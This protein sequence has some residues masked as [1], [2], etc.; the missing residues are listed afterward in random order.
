MRLLFLDGNRQKKKTHRR[1]N[2]QTKVLHNNLTPIYFWLTPKQ[3][4]YARARPDMVTLFNK[5]GG[6]MKTVGY[7]WFLIQLI[8]LGLFWAPLAYADNLSGVYQYVEEEGFILTVF[9]DHDEGGDNIRLII[10][11][12]LR[13]AYFEG[14]ARGPV[15]KSMAFHDAADHM[16]RIERSKSSFDIVYLSD[17]L[18]SSGL[19]SYIGETFTKTRDL[20]VELTPNLD[21]VRVYCGQDLKGGT[22]CFKDAAGQPQHYVINPNTG[23]DLDDS[24]IGKPMVIDF[25]RRDAYD[26]T[27]HQFVIK[28]YVSI[29]GILPE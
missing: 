5:Y 26:F 20:M 17:V 22:A 11:D 1:T 7:K 27:S 15:G 28:E 10:H 19:A 29:Q 8:G 21:K 4:L 3:R 6:V 2:A 12:D 16:L 9:L 18:L 14:Q 25:E 23:G 13:K 24:F